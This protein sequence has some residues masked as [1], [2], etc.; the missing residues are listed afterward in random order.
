MQTARGWSPRTP[1]GGKD[2]E[3]MNVRQTSTPA[4]SD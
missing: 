1:E 4:V 3:R 2:T